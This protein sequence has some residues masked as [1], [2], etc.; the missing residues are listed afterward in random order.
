[1]ERD[2]FQ[3]ARELLGAFTVANPCPKRSRREIVIRNQTVGS[4]AIEPAV[5]ATT[6]SDARLTPG[7]IQK[8]RV[9]AFT[10]A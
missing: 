7:Q 1:M 3:D 4:M 9:R 2:Q 5:C 6:G 8:Q 10:T